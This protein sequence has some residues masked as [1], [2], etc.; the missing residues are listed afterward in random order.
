[1]SAVAYYL[2][3]SGIA[4]AGIS[5]VRENTAA[6]RPP[7]FLWVSFPLG[8]PLGMPGDP[9]FQRRV[10][11]AALALLDAPAGPVLEDYLKDVPAP[12]TDAVVACPVSFPARLE[13]S[14]TWTAALRNEIALL[15]PW[16]VR[17]I[18]RRERTTVGIADAPVED[19]AIRLGSMLDATSGSAEAL[20]RTLPQLQRLKRTLSD[21]LAFHEEAVTAQPGDMPWQEVR[22]VL[23]QESVLGDAILTL[24]DRFRASGDPGLVAFTRVLVPRGALDD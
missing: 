2:E 1:M 18:E 9:S 7:R 12:P 24:R 23:W 4:T 5:L 10:I 8:R 20:P 22:R 16:H 19:L 14:G 13:G 17:S 3:A 15:R 11:L 6:L 21:L